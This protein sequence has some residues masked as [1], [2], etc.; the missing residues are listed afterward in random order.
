VRINGYRCD[1]CSQEYLVN[2]TSISSM[3]EGVPHNWFLVYHGKDMENRE[4][5]LFCT[6]RCLSVWTEDKIEPTYE[7]VARAEMPTRR[8]T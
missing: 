6:A 3:R 8:H 4:P 2:N 1:R 5:Y 7:Q